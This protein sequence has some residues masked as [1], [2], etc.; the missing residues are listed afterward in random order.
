MPP[1]GC[2]MFAACAVKLNVGPVMPGAAPYALV[3]TRNATTSIAARSSRVFES[4][5]FVFFALIGSLLALLS[6]LLVDVD[7]GHEPAEILGVVGQVV[8]IGRVKV[9]GPRRNRGG[10]VSDR[11]PR[12]TRIQQHVAQ[13]AT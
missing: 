5:T 4:A 12:G 8:E 2:V 7:F 11:V 3:V 1:S 6:A 9:L 10:A 13:L